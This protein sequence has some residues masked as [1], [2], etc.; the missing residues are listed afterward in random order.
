MTSMFIILL[1]SSGVF[2]GSDTVSQSQ[3]SNRQFIEL[4]VVVGFTFIP[5]TFDILAWENNS[6]H[7]RRGDRK[8]GRSPSFASTLIEIVH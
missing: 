7:S 2:I 3:Q 4:P 8:G 5:G 1:N 6:L